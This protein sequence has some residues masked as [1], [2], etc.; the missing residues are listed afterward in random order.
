MRIIDAQSI[1]EELYQDN[2]T[3]L[4][5]LPPHTCSDLEDIILKTG[6]SILLRAD[7][8]GGFAGACV[9]DVMWING[10]PRFS[11]YDRLKA[12]AH[13][14]CHWL[15]RAE[16]DSPTSFLFSRGDDYG[17]GRAFEE[18]IAEA[19]ERLVIR[20]QYALLEG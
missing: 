11:S 12:M 10:S 2:F 1:A 14:L 17:G 7:A 5:C 13:E 9:G 8:P 20:M 18:D 4:G 19:F 16:C 15:R 3:A 6:M